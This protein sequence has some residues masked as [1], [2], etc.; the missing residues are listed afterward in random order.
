GLGMCMPTFADC[1][2]MPVDGCEAATLI[3]DR[4]CGACGKTCGPVAQGTTSCQMGACAIAMCQTGFASC[5]SDATNGCET[6]LQGNVKNCGGC[7]TVCKDPTNASAGC[8]RGTC[9]VGTCNAG[10]GDCDNL[11]A[12]GC[13]SKLAGDTS[14]CGAYARACPFIAHGA[15][16]CMNGKCVVASCSQGF[17]DCDGVVA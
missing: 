7:G 3:D 13:K 10:F 15:G 17:A 9:G 8:S 1:N 5:D 12:N 4:N 6:D 11:A 2:G 16:A 14:N